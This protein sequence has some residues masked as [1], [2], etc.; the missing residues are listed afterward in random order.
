MQQPM[1]P[2]AIPFVLAPSQAFQ[3]AL[4]KFETSVV[5]KIWEQDTKSFPS[6]YEVGSNGT[7]TLLR[8]QKMLV[9]CYGHIL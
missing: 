4:L 9:H 8:S 1:P 3:N 5:L 6:S 2:Q 7:D